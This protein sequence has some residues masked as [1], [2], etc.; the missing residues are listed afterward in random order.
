MKKIKIIVLIL[1]VLILTGC[2]GEY[3]LII[4]KDLT[5]NEKVNLY[6]ENN[7]DAYEKTIKLFKNNNIDNSMYSIS[8][9][10]EYVNVSYEEKFKNFEDYFLNSKFY[11][12]FISQEDYKK[13]NKNINYAGTAN[14]KL[15]DNVSNSNLNNSFYITN[16]KINVKT[17]FEIK[18]NNADEVN[19]DTL[20]W[21]IKEQDTYRNFNFELSFL[22]NNN[23]YI[24]IILLCLG[25]IG[26]S[27]FIFIRN[28]FKEKRL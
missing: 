21:I 26:I 28:Y 5:I 16:L 15:D 20:T 12:I 2:K 9:S 14:L 4:N 3:N 23:L 27:A 19:N 6:I 7:N 17:P 8:Q 11:S 10:D 24:L 18:D 13:T 25:I 22:K 1:F